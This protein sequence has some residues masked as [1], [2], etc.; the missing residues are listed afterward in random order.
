MEYLQHLPVHQT[1]SAT[2]PPY[3]PTF[4]EHPAAAPQHL[5]SCNADE[6]HSGTFRRQYARKPVGINVAPVSLNSLK[7]VSDTNHAF[8]SAVNHLQPSRCATAQASC[9][10]YLTSPMTSCSLSVKPLAYFTPLSHSSPFL[11]PLPR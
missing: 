4:H 5:A 6:F 7:R 1:A 10:R 8:P 2:V 3:V 11:R 9:R